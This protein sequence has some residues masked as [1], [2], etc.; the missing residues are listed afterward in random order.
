MKLNLFY[1]LFFEHNTYNMQALKC[2]MKLRNN[3]ILSIFGTYIWLFSNYT[4]NDLY[5]KTNIN[6]NIL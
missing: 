4:E 6:Y 5:L 2:F 3:I 1:L